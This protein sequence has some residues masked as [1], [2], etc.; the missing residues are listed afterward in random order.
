MEEFGT[1]DPQST[2]TNTYM[3]EPVSEASVCTQIALDNRNSGTIT[4]QPSTSNNNNNST[5]QTANM[6]ESIR[7]PLNVTIKEEDDISFMVLEDSSDFSNSTACGDNESSD[8]FGQS[9]D[10]NNETLP[11]SSS[12]FGEEENAHTARKMKG[13]VK[14]FQVNCYCCFVF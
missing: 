10:V 11:L 3:T 12:N 7:L 6:S 13:H 4:T 8:M 5:S 2:A 1:V 14:L 9:Q